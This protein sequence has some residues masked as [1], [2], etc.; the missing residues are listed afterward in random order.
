[1]ELRQSLDP[2]S[3]EQDGVSDEHGRNHRDAGG[4][5]ETHNQSSTELCV[6]QWGGRRAGSSQEKTL[7]TQLSLY[8]PSEI[9]Y[10]V[11]ISLKSHLTLNYFDAWF[12]MDIYWKTT[13]QWCIVNICSDFGKYSNLFIFSLLCYDFILIFSLFNEGFLCFCL[14]IIHTYNILLAILNCNTTKLDKVMWIEYFK[15]CCLDCS[16]TWVS[17]DSVIGWPLTS[18][19]MTDASQGSL[20][21][22]MTL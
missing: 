7:N 20:W 13:V 8:V 10:F 16:N 22:M 15:G 2:H 18:M 3:Y 12:Q 19:Q 11:W 1:M 17:R 5:G 6:V 9:W 4:T 21:S 14:C